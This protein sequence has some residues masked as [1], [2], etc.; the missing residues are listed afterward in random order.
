MTY[1]E[2]VTQDDR[3]EKTVYPTQQDI[4]VT[5]EEV[6]AHIEQSNKTP[7]KKASDAEYE[8]VCENDGLVHDCLAELKERYEFDGFPASANPQTL[9]DVFIA[10]VRLE[11]FQAVDEDEDDEEESHGQ[12]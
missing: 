3:S 11:E 10:N 12:S 5:W 8:L 4:F 2:A 6:Q 7:K 9:M 1:K